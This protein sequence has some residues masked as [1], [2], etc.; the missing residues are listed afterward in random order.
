MS[1]GRQ[2]IGDDFKSQLDGTPMDLL[3]DT[4]AAKNGVEAP[5]AKA[6]KT[7]K[8]SNLKKVKAVQINGEVAPSITQAKERMTVQIS[9]DT[10]ERVKDCVYWNRLTVAQFVEEAL[11]AALSESEKQNGKPYPKRRSELK[12]GRPTK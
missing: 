3:L 7:L 10:I 8:T 4:P 2:T 1:K 5:T 11:E 9:K 6:E 12:P